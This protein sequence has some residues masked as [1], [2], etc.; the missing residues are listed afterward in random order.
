M[1]IILCQKPGCLTWMATKTSFNL[2]TQGQFCSLWPYRRPINETVDQSHFSHT[3]HKTNLQKWCE[4]STW[5][6]TKYYW[7]LYSHPRKRTTYASE[8]LKFLSLPKGRI[9]AVW[10]CNNYPDQHSSADPEKYCMAMTASA[11]CSVEDVTSRHFLCWCHVIFL[12]LCQLWMS[13]HDVTDFSV[14]KGCGTKFL[15]NFI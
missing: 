15:L 7:G 5:N 12:L 8:H 9:S 10:P 14:S 2:A 6:V 3:F 13:R 4:G 11:L 1:C